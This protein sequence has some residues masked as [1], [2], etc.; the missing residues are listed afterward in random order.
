M[1]VGYPRG[2]G[3]QEKTVMYAAVLRAGRGRWLNDISAAD[4]R[5]ASNFKPCVFLNDQA[6]SSQ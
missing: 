6:R 4:N 2:G 5:A 3:T 1:V